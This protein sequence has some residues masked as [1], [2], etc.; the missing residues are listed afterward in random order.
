MPKLP[1]KMHL[2]HGA[3]YFVSRNKWTNLGRDY[4]EALRR[5]AD[6]ISRKDGSVPA[7]ID[8]WLAGKVVAESTRI[9]YTLVAK[10]LQTAF[11]AFNPDDVKPCHFYQLI[12][13]K[14]ISD[15]M[16]SIYR[17]VMIGA[18]QLAVEEG[19]IERNPIREVKNYLSKKRGRY[20]TD[21]EFH[22]I[23]DK[24]SPTM[25]ALMLVLY[26]TGQ[27]ISDVLSIRY[28][29]IGEDGI[30]FQQQ[31]TGKRLCVKWSDELRDAVAQAK[32]LHTS[33]KGLTLF[34]TR[35]GTIISYSTVRTLWNRAIKRSGI[36]DAHIHD[37]RAKT[38]TD[39]KKQG[40]DA[41]ALLGHMSETTALRYQRSREIPLVEPVR[42]QRA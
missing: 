21:T 28:S 33:V 37:I 13:G 3:Y 39:A 42:L 9:N 20:L 10:R 6:L 16:A 5:Y 15:S 19:V 8:R 25:G 14:G 4:A 26:L 31:K 40:I 24:A 36:E 23:L 30:D 7:L 22:A 12:A 27:R 11:V 35:Q 18:M 29:Q 41:Q 34:H 17:S 38:A 2:K 32:A 1:A